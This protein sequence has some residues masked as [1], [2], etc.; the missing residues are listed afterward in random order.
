MRDGFTFPGSF[1]L[2]PLVAIPA[3]MHT[4]QQEQSDQQHHPYTRQIDRVEC[5][6]QPPVRPFCRHAVGIRPIGAGY[7]CRVDL[8]E[9]VHLAR[10][11]PRVE[12]TVALGELAGRRVDWDTTP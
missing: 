10:A 7:A 6:V 5:R 3:E 4:Y 11:F 12:A 8:W 9:Y 1:G 2:L